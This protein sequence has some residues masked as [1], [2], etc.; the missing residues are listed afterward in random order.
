MNIRNNIIDKLE[1]DADD[2]FYALSIG[3]KSGEVVYIDGISR[4]EKNGYINFAKHSRETMLLEIDNSL[5]RIQAEDIESVS[6]KQY[7]TKM[8][9]SQRWF[10]NL[11]LSQSRFGRSTYFMWIKFFLFGAFLSF[12][13]AG[14]TTVIGGGDVMGVLM[15]SSLFK[16]LLETGGSYIGKV[17]LVIF[18]IMVITF[19]IDLSLPS[20]EPFKKIKPYSDYASNTRLQNLI[21]ILLFLVF[22][23]I[24][25]VIISTLL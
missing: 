5:W 2:F 24:V 8:D 13:L 23:N 12:I 18:L 10:Y 17:F 3:L 11:F 14:M 9:K 16:V 22:Y 1:K 6:V 15:D 19:I 7:K 20:E 25:A 21:I 4:G